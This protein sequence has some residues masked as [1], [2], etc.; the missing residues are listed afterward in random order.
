[1]FLETNPVPLKHALSLLDLMSPR[2]RL[3]LV[4]PTEAT[5]AK[6]A[7]LM[8]QIRDENA[9]YMPRKVSAGGPSNRPH[10]NSPAGRC[11]PICRPHR[12]RASTRT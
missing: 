4:E 8:A 2:V 1:L 5:K 6:L 11:P 3:P 12:R 10:R 7:V 9:E